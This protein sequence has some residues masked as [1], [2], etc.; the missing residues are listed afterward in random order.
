[1]SFK[2]IKRGERIYCD[3][4]ENVRVNG[5]VVQKHLRYI[6]TIWTNPSTFPSIMSISAT[7]P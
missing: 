5:K 7:M 2:K 4:V 3:E 6:G 1:M